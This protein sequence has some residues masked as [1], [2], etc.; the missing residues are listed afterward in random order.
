[1]YQCSPGN[2]QFFCVWF[3][4]CLAWLLFVTW[5]KGIMPF[6]HKNRV[7]SYHSPIPKFYLWAISINTKWYTIS[8]E[9]YCLAAL[10]KKRF[11]YYA[12]GQ[13]EKQ[14]APLFTQCENFVYKTMSRVTTVSAAHIYHCFLYRP[15]IASDLMWLPFQLYGDPSQ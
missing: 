11:C 2:A 13:S 15:S 10:C 6:H 4:V 12:L 1:M 14:S 8:Y 3:L 9:E 5:L 7:I